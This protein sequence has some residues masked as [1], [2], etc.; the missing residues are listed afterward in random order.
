VA[1]VEIGNR[2]KIEICESGHERRQSENRADWNSSRASE[3]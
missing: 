2:W 1:G 3:E